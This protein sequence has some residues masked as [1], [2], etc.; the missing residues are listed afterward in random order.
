MVYAYPWLNE[1]PLY[2]PSVFNFFQPSY[3]LAGPLTQAG[4]VAP[5]FQITN[6]A[7]LV[8]TDNLLQYQAYQYVDSAGN[9]YAGPDFDMLSLMAADNTFLH[10]AQWEPLAADPG[11]LVDE[12]NLVLM[13]GQMS[14]A[15]RTVLVN[16]ATSIPA[17]SP[18]TRV[19]ETAELLITSP[20][21]AIQR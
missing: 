14:T 21:Y 18:A 9:R 20:E 1:Y 8:N 2:S 10:T 4:L 6:E 7:S 16:Y 13:G 5:E 15:M 19:A 17:T 3:Q 11:S 12:M